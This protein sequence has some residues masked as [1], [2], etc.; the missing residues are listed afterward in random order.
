MDWTETE[1]PPGRIETIEQLFMLKVHII[2]KFK[3]ID[4]LDVAYI[5]VQMGYE[6]G[7]NDCTMSSL[8]VYTIHL[9]YLGRLTLED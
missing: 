9:I 3:K 2:S 6:W 1:S 5:L 7:V 8:I 4:I